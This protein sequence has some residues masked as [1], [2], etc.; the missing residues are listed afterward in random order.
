M[1]FFI[2]EEQKKMRKAKILQ[3]KLKR[4]V[5]DFY[6]NGSLG[7]APDI[8][9]PKLEPL[10]TQQ[11]NPSGNNFPPKLERV[12]SINSEA[13]VS[14]FADVSF[15]NFVD[16]KE[17]SME[18]ASNDKQQH[19]S[20]DNILR[21]HLSAGPPLN[22]NIPMEMMSP[23]DPI[24][25]ILP[26]NSQ[27]GIPTPDVS[28]PSTASSDVTAG[29]HF[30]PIDVEDP[31]EAAPVRQKK[32]RVSQSSDYL[33]NLPHG[34]VTT[35]N[36]VLK[37]SESEEL[38]VKDLP[39]P[40]LNPS[41]GAVFEGFNLD[42]EVFMKHIGQLRYASSTAYDSARKKDQRCPRDPSYVQ[43]FNFSETSIK[44]LVT[45]AKNL[46]PFLDLSTDD[47][48]LLLKNS[49]L[50]M[51]VLGSA[52]NYDHKLKG[53]VVVDG[54]EVRTIETTTVKSTT[55]GKQ[56]IGH[57]EM[58]ILYVLSACQRDLGI[59]ILLTVLSLFSM[60]G[61]TADSTIQDK[62]KVQEGYEIYENV[63]KKYTHVKYP[64]RPNMMSNLMRSLDI[65][66]DFSET[67]MQSIL[68][69]PLNKINPLLL[70]IFDLP[71]P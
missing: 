70:E 17:E 58:I 64:N 43:I 37:Y 8:Q 4:G 32:Q 38:C 20:F 36:K 13:Y 31:A 61:R 19:E 40:M 52:S 56:L 24:E 69:S 62:D 11:P 44:C 23:M 12:P 3:N 71:M 2:G 6:P 27:S 54:S 46:E 9:P 63:L 55:E 67:Y 60:Q 41:Y 22:L 65:V 47:Q 66:R 1:H 57:Y 34:I 16:R 49:I 48:I 33:S 39:E 14:S 59:I 45:L 5:Q 7:F 42:D 10:Q 25:S 15:E 21:P 50:E 29:F 35:T 30:G 18:M 28:N 68:K 51:M 26:G 53:W